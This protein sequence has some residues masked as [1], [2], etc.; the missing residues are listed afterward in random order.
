M[1]F[2][3]FLYQFFIFYIPLLFALSFHE[4]SH[5]FVSKKKGDVTAEMQGRLTLNPI[6]H[7]DLLG[8]VILPLV[9]IATHLPVFGWAK[10]V[11]V[12]ESVLKHPK[13]DMFWIALAGPLSNVL[14]AVIG[15][16]ITMLL[17]LLSF[18]DEIVLKWCQIFIYIN[19]LLAFFNL[20]PLHPLDG[21]K[22]IA[23]F[24][25]FRWNE[26][27]ERTQMYSSWILIALFVMGGFQLISG[28]AFLLT[29]VLVN[30]PQWV[31][32]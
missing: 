16:F 10:P 23:R 27:L 7:M 3:D 15:S 13:Q 31:F 25:P 17:Y 2:L 12:R 14:L 26:W 4:Y 21:G 19:L 32:G 5:A 24:L 1:F 28:P 8:T 6:A 18:H 30:W 20:L 11:P 29:H 22:I 9:A